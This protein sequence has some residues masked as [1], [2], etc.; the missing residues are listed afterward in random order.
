M[1][2]DRGVSGMWGYGY[3]SSY[4]WF[5]LMNCTVFVKRRSLQR[6]QLPQSSKLTAKKLSKLSGAAE[7]VLMNFWPFLHPRPD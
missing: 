5:T 1:H 3:T 2:L 6:F 4:R 7:I